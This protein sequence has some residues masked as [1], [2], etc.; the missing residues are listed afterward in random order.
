MGGPDIFPYKPG[1]V[2][3]SYHLIHDVGT[4]V[5]VGVALQDGNYEHINPKTKGSHAARDL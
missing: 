5:P 4:N 3:N 2:N 1:Q